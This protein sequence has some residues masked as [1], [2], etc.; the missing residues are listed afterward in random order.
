MTVHLLKLGHRRIGFVKGHPNHTAS[1]ERLEGFQQALAEA[2]D[3][4]AMIVQGYFSFDDGLSAAEQLLDAPV[5]P[6]AIFAS[7]DDMPR[8]PSR[9]RN[10]GASMCRAT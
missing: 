1:A 10:D 9:W 5:P 7:N 2:K 8:P 3:A 4:E 6:T